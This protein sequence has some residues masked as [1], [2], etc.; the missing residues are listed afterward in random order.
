V[1]AVELPPR[2]QPID[3]TN[4]IAARMPTRVLGTRVTDRNIADP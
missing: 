2:A 1:G 4:A 3:P